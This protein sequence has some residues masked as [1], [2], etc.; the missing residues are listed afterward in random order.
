MELER[1]RS[2]ALAG[3]G[4]IFVGT[5]IIGVS[6]NVSNVGT[7]VGVCA[8]YSFA[9]ALQFGGRAGCF[10]T[11]TGPARVFLP[12]LGTGPPPTLMMPAMQENAG[13]LSEQ[14]TARFPNCTCL[15]IRFYQQNL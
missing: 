5:A 14:A 10:R 11:Q 1:W 15:R 8:L 2:A 7:V 12:L 3:R 4:S 6:I 13:R 9:D